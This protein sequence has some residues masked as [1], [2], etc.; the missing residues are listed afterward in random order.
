VSTRD[1]LVDLEL[2]KHFNT[3]RAI[4]V[5][6]HGEDSSAV[7]LAFSLIEV[8]PG[9]NGMVAVTLPTWLAIEKGLV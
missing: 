1:K 8:A 3:D 6:Q 5:S 2:H 4:R 7:W 9:S